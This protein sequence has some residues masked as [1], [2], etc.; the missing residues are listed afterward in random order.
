MAA[1]KTNYVDDVL[2]ASVNDKRKYNMIQNA[3]GTVS[4]DDVTTYTQNGDSFG[5]KDINDTNTAVNVLN[6]NLTAEDNLQF[7]FGKDGDGNYG[8]YGA[9]G[10]LIPFK[11]D[12]IYNFYGEIYKHAN[13]AASPNGT[14]GY[15]DNGWQYL[16]C[17]GAG[18]GV[19][20]VKK[21]DLTKFS[22]LLFQSKKDLGLSAMYFYISTQSYF[23]D[24]LWNIDSNV[25]KKVGIG[26]DIYCVDIK[27]LV[28]E[29]YV[30]I[31]IGNNSD[32]HEMKLSYSPIYC[33]ES[34]LFVV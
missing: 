15:L 20:S 33:F 7:R 24:T 14:L 16:N 19:A 8:Y 29:Y 12:A 28:G 10:S 11:S 34:E 25:V 18:G 2:D 13:V 1:L 9:D 30:G 17:K 26:S 5:A 4:F 27:D 21:I 6:E 3:D 31:C 32:T 22:S 23:Y